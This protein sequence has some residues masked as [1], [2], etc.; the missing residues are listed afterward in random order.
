MLVGPSLPPDKIHEI[1]DALCAAQEKDK[2]MTPQEIKLTAHDGSTKC[3]LGILPD[4]RCAVVVRLLGGSVLTLLNPHSPTFE[5]IWSRVE[6]YAIIRL[7]EP[8][9]VIEVGDVV[10]FCTKKPPEYT[11]V[12]MAIHK[13]EVWV[14][15][16]EALGCETYTLKDLILVRKGDRS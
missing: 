10:T 4:V 2:I 5:E 15:E 12:V 13:D 3:P 7:V 11:G 6:G 16:G 8:D 1:L 14:D 9:P